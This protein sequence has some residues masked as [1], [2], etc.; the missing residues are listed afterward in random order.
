MKL[1]VLNGGQ[2]YAEKGFFLHGSGE[3]RPGNQGRAS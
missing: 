3:G 2:L 1:Y